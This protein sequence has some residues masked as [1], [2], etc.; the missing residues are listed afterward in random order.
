M[1]RTEEKILCET[2]TPGKQGT[3]IL[4]WKYDLVRDALRRVVPKSKAGIAFS[5]LAPLVG[6]ALSE[7]DR[8]RLGSLMWYLTTVKLHMEVI[9]ELERVPDVVPQRLRRR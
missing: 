9:G 4:R 1:A 5:D 7:A 2:P 3:R 8:K 6:A